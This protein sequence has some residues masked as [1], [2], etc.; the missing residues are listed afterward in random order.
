MLNPKSQIKFETDFSEEKIGE[1]FM[2]EGGVE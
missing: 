2:W 1:Y